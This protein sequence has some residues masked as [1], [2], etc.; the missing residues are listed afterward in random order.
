MLISTIPEFKELSFRKE[1]LSD[2][3]TMAY[4]HAYGGAIGFEESRWE[5]WYQRWILDQSGQRFYR[6]LYSDIEECYVGEI[7]YHYDEEVNGMMCDVLIHDCFRGQGYG[8]EGLLLLCQ[9]AQNNH[10]DTL[11]DLIASDNPA[12]HLFLKCGF[13]IIERRTENTLVRKVL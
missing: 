3:K 5:S 12:C 8:K 7:S 13:E 1:L 10:V 6:Y 2:E 4:N 9:H 11:Y